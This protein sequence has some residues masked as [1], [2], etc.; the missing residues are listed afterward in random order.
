MKKK[1]VLIIEDLE[2]QRVALHEQLAVR[3]FEVYS[4][5]SVAEARALAEQHWNDLDVAVLDMRLEDPSDRSMTGADI[6]MEYR[7][8]KSND[9]CE[10]LIY[11]AY[12]ELDYYRLALKLG[13]AAYLSKTGEV[14][15]VARNLTDAIQHVRVL[16]LRRALNSDNPATIDKVARIAAC[17]QNRKEAVLRFCQNVLKPEF[18]SCLGGPFIVLFS[19]GNLTQ[20]VA[21]SQGLPQGTPDF[22]HTLQALA[23]GNGNVAEPLVLDASELEKAADAETNQL[24]E[25]L[26][27]AAFLPLSISQDFR[28]SIGIL[29]Q[30]APE[31][32]VPEDAKELSRLLAQYLRPTVLENM[33]KIWPRWTELKAT[34][35]SAARLCLFV[36]Q[37]LKYMLPS[38][39]K[40]ER[41]WPENSLSRLWRL[42]DDMS[43]TGELLRDLEERRWSDKSELVSVKAIAESAWSWITEGE[44]H[45]NESF[46]I[47]GDC[48]IETDKRDLDVAVSRLLFWL[49][50][51]RSATPVNEAPLVTV[52]CIDHI[53]GPTIIFEDRSQRLHQNLRAEMFAPFSQAVQVPFAL[54]SMATVDNGAQVAAAEHDSNPGRYLPLYLAKMLVEGRYHGRLEDHSDD[55][56]LKDRTYGHRIVM[57]FPRSVREGE[58]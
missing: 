35:S 57:Q 23:H 32:P 58:N 20:N 8:K 15:K 2:P 28:L 50:Q 46:E 30:H 19:A 40:D 42:A 4:A 29:Q 17:S 6:G 18:E 36:G 34:R 37:E 14:G 38:R 16:A 26:D 45:A 56:D 3:G 51:R 47:S 10:F 31:T 7:N 52:K 22:Y 55:K 9:T 27:G 44:E 43:D 13:V 1:K 48:M 21:A 11:S 54:E 5:G 39:D 49:A 12:A 41:S 24:C 25:R 53:D 33:L